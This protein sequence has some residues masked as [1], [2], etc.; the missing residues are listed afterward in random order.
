M[1]MEL[2]KK[3]LELIRYCVIS[4]FG[5]NY[6]CEGINLNDFANRITDLIGEIK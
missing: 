6:I 3:E 4:Q 2:S 5:R 1:L